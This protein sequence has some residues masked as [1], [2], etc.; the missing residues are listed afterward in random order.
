M[1]VFVQ[2]G[3]GVMI[4]FPVLRQPIAFSSPNAN[5]VFSVGSMGYVY[6]G[7]AYYAGSS[8]PVGYLKSH[9]LIIDGAG[10]EESPFVLSQT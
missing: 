1:D 5:L 8:R 4:Q 7:G 2:V 10:T 3:L 9:V 6:G